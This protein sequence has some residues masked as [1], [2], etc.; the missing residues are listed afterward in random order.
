MNS[1]TDRERLLMRY[2]DGR[3][4]AEEARAVSAWLREDAAARAW[5]RELAEQAVALGDLSRERNWRGVGG[6]PSPANVIAPRFT[7]PAWLALAASL[8][9]LGCL[10]AFWFGGR[11]AAPRMVVEVEE[12]SGALNWTGPSGG[13]RVGLLRGTKLSAGLL[14]TAGEG[15][16]AQL[17][18]ADGT[19]VTLGNGTQVAFA[20]DG[21]KQLRLK[22]GSLTC[23]VTAQPVGR[24]LVVRTPTAILEVLGTVFS[25]TASGDETMLKVEEGRVR[26]ERLTDGSV[27]EVASQQT[28]VAAVSQ[29]AQLQVR[30]EAAPPVRWQRTFEL[31]PLPHWKGD[32]QPA[33]GGEPA[34]VRAVPCVAG[35]REDGMPVYQLGITARGEGTHLATLLP[36]SVVRL[37]WRT[38]RPATVRVMLTV[39]KVDGRFGGN[40]V[41]RIPKETT[42]AGP[43]GWRSATVPLRDF[44]ALLLKHPAPPER[45]QVSLIFVTTATDDTDL[46]LA[47]LAI[48]PAGSTPL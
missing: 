46:Q 47:E 24:P 18:F 43:G 44:E 27:V 5:L 11:F 35:Q 28:A 30:P 19:R 6:K 36:D 39:Q 26:L 38:A 40:F 45:G 12:V 7:R 41:A 31:P 21:Q 15:A 13:L 2:L 42:P 3:L 37:R 23:E 34:L 33:G 10:A 4:S 9:V 20:E 48:E 16:A 1:Y 14:E 29:T 25:V 22:T 17:R 32:W 8:A